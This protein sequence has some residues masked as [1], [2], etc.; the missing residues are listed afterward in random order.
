MSNAHLYERQLSC[1]I[2]PYIQLH[3]SSI[4]SC[5]HGGGSGNCLLKVLI[6]QEKELDEQ[7]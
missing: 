4:R 6:M 7:M 5:I 1:C 3:N 2:Y